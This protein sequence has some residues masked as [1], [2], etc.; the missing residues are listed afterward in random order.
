MKSKNQGLNLNLHEKKP[1]F[2]VSDGFWLSPI[3]YLKDY[4]IK[5]RTSLSS[6]DLAASVCNITLIT[7]NEISP[8]LASEKVIVLL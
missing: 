6:S 3:W 4:R 5:M 1:N 8:L 7:S 2:T